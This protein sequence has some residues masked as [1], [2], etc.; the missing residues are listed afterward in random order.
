LTDKTQ[1]YITSE[2]ALMKKSQHENI[3]NFIA[4]YRVESFLWVVMEFMEAGTLTDVIECLPVGGMPE[5]V[6]GFICR[7]VLKGLSYIHAMHRIHRDIKSDNVLLGCDGRVKLADFG[8][9]AQ[10]TKQQSKRQTFVGTPNWMAPEIMKG[11]HYDD[12]VDI[13]SSGVLLTEMIEK[14]PPYMDLPPMR[15]VYMIC[16]QGIP[17]AQNPDKWSNNL[18]DFHQSCLK[19]EPKDRPSALDLLRLPF[20]SSAN[21]AQSKELA[22]IIVKNKK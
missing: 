6:I 14:K 13:W 18:K 11:E 12:K 15:V 19:R 22:Q 21:V 10:L 9:T 16:T 20:V 7:E 4:A 17:P 5:P 3:V 8:F 1:K 2:I